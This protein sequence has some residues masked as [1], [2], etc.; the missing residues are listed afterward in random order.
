MFR[1]YIFL[2]PDNGASGIDSSDEMNEG[3]DINQ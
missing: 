3:G 1:L 2:H